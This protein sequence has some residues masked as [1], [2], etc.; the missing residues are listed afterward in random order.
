M[1]GRFIVRI[2]AGERAEPLDSW[3]SLPNQIMNEW[4]KNILELMYKGI[5]APAAGFFFGLCGQNVNGQGLIDRTKTLGTLSG[6]P[7]LIHGYARQGVNRDGTAAGWPTISQ[8]NGV[9]MLQSK[10]VTFT[11]AG[12]D[13]GQVFRMFVAT[14]NDN[15][16]KLVAMSAQF[17]AG[18]GT[19]LTNGNSIIASYQIYME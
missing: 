6:E 9:W 13:I 5:N 17:N 10:T 3:N 12:G 1:K 2:G 18:A 19:N 16:G 14:S 15:S 8:V 11:A 4:D 7:A